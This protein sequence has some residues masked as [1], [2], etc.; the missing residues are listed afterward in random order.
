MLRFVQIATAD[1]FDFIGHCSVHTRCAMLGVRI[2]PRIDNLCS[3]Y[4]H[5]DLLAQ[6]GRNLKALHA[7]LVVM[8]VR[9][10]ATVTVF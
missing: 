4:I 8:C 9:L 5:Q 7:E 1:F 10:L 6:A 3:F 2:R